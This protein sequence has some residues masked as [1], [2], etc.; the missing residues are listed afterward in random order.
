MT[1]SNGADV[2]QHDGLVSRFDHG[3]FAGL[4]I[5]CRRTELPGDGRA[6]N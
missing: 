3:Q 1:G 4:R 6:R 5:N 2:G